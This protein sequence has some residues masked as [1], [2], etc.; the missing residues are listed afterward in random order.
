MDLSA[1][2]TWEF[3][4]QA[5]IIVVSIVIGNIIRRKV[6]FISNSLLP[7]SVIGGLLIFILKFIPGVS[8][9]IDSGIMEIITYHCLGIGFIALA[10]KTGK[11]TK[12]TN[13]KLV[14][15]DA[16]IITVLGYLV[17]AII[18]LGITISLAV[19][20]MPDLFPAAGLLLPMGFGQGTGQALNM[21][22]VFENLG[23]INGTTFGLAIAAVGFIVACV[24]GVIYLNYLKSKGKL[25]EQVKRIAL[26]NEMKSNI[27]DEDEAPLNESVDKLTIQLGLIFI[28][29]MI[30]YGVISLGSYLSIEFLGN[31]GKNTVS[32]LLW[33]FNFLF[34]SVFAML[35]KKVMEALKKKGIMTHQH[36]NNYLMNRI[37]GL[38][39]DIMIVAGIAAIDW[40]NLEGLLIPLILVCVLGTIATFF[41]VKFVCNKT[42][43]GYEHEAF[44]SIFGMLTGTASTGMIL[45]REIDPNFETPAADNLV[46]QQVP[47]IA[48]GAPI[49]LLIP[50]A[51]ES[52]TNALIVFGI[53]IVMFVVYNIILLRKYIFKKKSA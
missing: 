1:Y 30:T 9:A 12:D 8:S 36:V 2:K 7:S 26:N 39:F 31:F 22:K 37:S 35:V 45:L 51:G 46:L 41:F 33:G 44:F 28:V 23:F 47:A 20:L 24:C 40:K 29:Y 27:Y 21:G 15:M 5:S 16:G 6:K 10:L 3:I 53:V 4:I 49:L 11:K 52:L 42:F 50:F 14:I 13:N 18:G 34:G 38:F 43:K 17:Q 25:S 19:T 48:F 32:P